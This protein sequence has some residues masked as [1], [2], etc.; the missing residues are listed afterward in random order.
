MEHNDKLHYFR[1]TGELNNKGGFEYEEKP[2]ELKRMELEDGDD[3]SE[4]MVMVSDEDYDSG[5]E[6][7]E[8]EQ[9][10]HE[11]NANEQDVS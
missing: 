5:E 6:A 7:P 4:Q 8:E 10:N 9:N 3:D 11:D 2:P 1:K